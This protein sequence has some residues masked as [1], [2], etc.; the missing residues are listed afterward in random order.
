MSSNNDEYICAVDLYVKTHTM[1]LLSFHM[2][3]FLD[4]VFHNIP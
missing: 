1:S 2:F 4:I 3:V